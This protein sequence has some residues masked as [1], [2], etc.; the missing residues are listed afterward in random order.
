MKKSETKK[1]RTTLA[2]EIAKV[3]RGRKRGLSVNEIAAKIEAKPGSVRRTLDRLM[4]GREAY[5]IEDGPP[6]CSVTGRVVN[7]YALHALHGKAGA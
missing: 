7:R 6:R 1:A 3:L 4:V 2:N 5:T